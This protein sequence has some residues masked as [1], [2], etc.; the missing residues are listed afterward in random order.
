MLYRITLDLELAPLPEAEMR[1]HALDQ[2]I[3][4]GELEVAPPT[5]EWLGEKIAVLLTSGQCP[6]EAIFA[7]SEI[8]WR[9]KTATCLSAENAPNEAD[10][11]HEEMVSAIQKD[12]DRGAAKREGT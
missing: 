2:M 4:V 6:D 8:Y 3:E 11:V 5:P 12:I 7:G 1:Q 9:V 10:D